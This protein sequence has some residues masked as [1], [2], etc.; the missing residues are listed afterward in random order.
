MKC[1]K[2]GNEM[3]EG[4]EQVG[5][6]NFSNPIYHK[7]VYC[8][9]C[10]IKFDLDVINSDQRNAKKESV[11]G[12]IGLISSF[13]FCNI[14]FPIA[15]F[16]LSIIGLCNK[17]KK[18]VCGTIGLIVSI[19]TIMLNIL[20]PQF[21]KYVDKAKEEIQI[22]EESGIGNVEDTEESQDG[23]PITEF[24]NV[25][26][27]FFLEN[28]ENN[29]TAEWEKDIVSEKE[30][31]FNDIPWN[32]AF[33]DVSE[34]LSAWDLWNISGEGYKTCSVDD[35]LLGD[36]KGI[37]FDYSGINII[38]HAFN[39]EQEVA[40][41]TTTD[42]ILYFSY[43]PVEEYLTYEESDTAL[44]GAQYVFKPVNL[45]DMY[46]DLIHKISEIYG[47]PNKQT[48]ETDLWQ[49]QYTYT[50]WYGANNTELVLKSL[51][52]ENDTTDLY[53]D[54]IYLTYAWRGGDELLKNASD[55]VKKEKSDKEKDAQGEENLTGL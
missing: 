25:S 18:S 1:T 27:E 23:I 41:Y 2:C 14:L 37:D 55:A 16:I 49:N 48:T 12:I 33:P 22:S 15:G 39:G 45:Q 30:I 29:E 50:Y 32:T 20:A 19:F 3:R 42:I 54:E 17:T 51:N 36:Y 34:K 7:F 24:D 53:D 40:G 38:S 11:C 44:Y 31:I 47:E 21:M 4:Q 10:M 6:D 52:S 43:L 9:K 35:I 26:D 8:D 13:I 5:K 46:D 28:K